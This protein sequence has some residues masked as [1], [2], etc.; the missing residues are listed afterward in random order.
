MVEKDQKKK[1]KE[2]KEVKR[3]PVEGEVEGMK[4]DV[5]RAGKRLIFHITTVFFIGKSALVF[6]LFTVDYCIVI[7]LFRRLQSSMIVC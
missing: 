6:L 3:R 7:L 1:K 5:W 2:K 4:I